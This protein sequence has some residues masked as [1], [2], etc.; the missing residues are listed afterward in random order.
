[1]KVIF[2]FV[3][4][5]GLIS[6]VAFKKYNEKSV[7]WSPFVTYRDLI[8]TG[9]LILVNWM[10][11][12]KG[13]CFSSSVFSSVSSISPIYKICPSASMGE[14]DLIIEEG[15]NASPSRKKF[16]SD[17]V[18]TAICVLSSLSKTP[19][20]TSSFSC[21]LWVALI[22]YVFH[23]AIVL[24]TESMSAKSATYKV[25]FSCELSILFFSFG[26]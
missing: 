20:R 13:L 6:A 26:C 21:R 15:K 19:L 14:G 2:A 11:P 10:L 23:E 7:Y 25:Y 3:S 1:M 22:L 5:R 17:I 12:S 24:T 16:F 8:T 18:F 9:M 4:G